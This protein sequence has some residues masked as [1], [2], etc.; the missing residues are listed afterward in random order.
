M[1]ERKAFSFVEFKSVDEEGNFKGVLSTYNNEDLVG[2]ICDPGCFDTSVKA[3]GTKRPLLWQHMYFEPIGSFSITDT[4]DNL[5][6]D[7]HFNM[8]VQ[9][10]REAYSLLKA[11]DVNGLS[12]GFQLVDADYIDGIRHIKEADLI[13]G[14][15]VTFPANPEAFAEAKHMNNQNRG[16]L[17]KQISATESFKA[18]DPELQKRLMKAV[19]DAMA[20]EADCGDEDDKKSEEEETNNEDETEGEDGEGEQ[21]N[22]DDTQDESETDEEDM[23]ALLKGI[24]DLKSGLEDLSKSMKEVE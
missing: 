9:R 19:D 8:A 22:T 13:E 20:D 1:T 12:I 15:F 3:R 18:L 23:K 24:S 7:G 14:S 17:R 16:L 4:K 5:A 2:D 11:G 6:V 21:P 10:G